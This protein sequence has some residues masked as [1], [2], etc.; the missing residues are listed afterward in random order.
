MEDN[1]KPYKGAEKIKH[2]TSYIEWFEFKY[3]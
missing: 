2:A 1:Q 3:G